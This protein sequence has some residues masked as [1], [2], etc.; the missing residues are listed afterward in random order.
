MNIQAQV[1]AQPALC[2]LAQAVHDTGLLEALLL[3]CL[4]ILTNDQLMDCRATGAAWAALE[5]PDADIRCITFGSPRVANKVFGKAF[6]ALVGTSLRLVHGF[7]PV[8][9]LPPSLM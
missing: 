9:S 2:L 3:C 4:P 1:S 5:Y 7:D 8:P 6:N